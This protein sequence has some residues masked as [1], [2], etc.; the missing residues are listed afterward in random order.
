MLYSAL[1]FVGDTLERDNL[2]GEVLLGEAI[3]LLD[4]ETYVYITPL[5]KGRALS[6]HSN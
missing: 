1:F 6:Y 2:V 5:P 3:I 4:G